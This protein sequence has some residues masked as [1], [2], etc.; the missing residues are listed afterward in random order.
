MNRKDMP[1]TANDILNEVNSE[2]FFKALDRLHHHWHLLSDVKLAVQ[3]MYNVA[4]P[5][6]AYGTTLQYMI[7]LTVLFYICILVLS[8]HPS[9]FKLQRPED[10]VTI[11]LSLTL[12]ACTRVNG[13]HSVGLCV[14]V[15]YRASCYIPL[16]YIESQVPLGFPRCSQCMYCVDLLKRLVKKFWWDLLIT[17]TFFASWWTLDG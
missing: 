5:G 11:L 1:R 2:R 9:L 3:N 7:H 13:S 6:S 12:G 15:C 17:S 14:C 8:R 10:R 16:L 4:D